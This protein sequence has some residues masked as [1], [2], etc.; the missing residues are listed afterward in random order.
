M[1]D[2]LGKTLGQYQIVELTRDA[3]STLIYKGFQPNMNRFV[4]VEVLKS[5]EPLAV[6]SFTHQ[7]ELL[8]R[9]QHANILPIYDSG[10]AEGVN[11][12]VMRFPEGGVLQD[13]MMQYYSLSAATGL[14]AGVTAGLEKIHA[15]GLVHGNLQPGNTYLDEAGQPLLTDFSLSRTASTPITPFLSPEQVR[16]GIVDQRTDVYALGVLLYEMVTGEAPPAGVIV[17]PRAKRPDLP[18]SVEKVV[19]KAMAQNPDVRFQSAREFQNALST[20]IQPVIPVQSYSSQPQTYQPVPYRR[21]TNWAAIILGVLLV[22]V[23]VGGMGFVFG[24]WGN[25]ASAPVAGEPVAPPVEA[26]PTTAPEIP[27]VP[28]EPPEEAPVEPP[29]EPQPTSPP[30]ADAPIQLPAVCG[31]LGVAGGFVL[32]GSASMLRKKSAMSRTRKH[33]AQK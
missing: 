14:L 33:N 5:H 16:G 3:G 31:S 8:A 27:E 4:M 1:S 10:Q 28:I 20:A 21:G 29:A 15:L 22:A 26:P 11:Y 32:L 24:W 2:M 17:S 7:N 19:F 18:E 9:I 30:G 25:Q 23:L 6:Q 12:R 13:H